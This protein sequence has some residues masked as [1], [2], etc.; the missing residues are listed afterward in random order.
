MIT[1]L[2]TWDTS[3]R[4]NIN[5]NVAA[6]H[7]AVDAILDATLNV[8]AVVVAES[9][10]MSS[11]S[12]LSLQLSTLR[13]RVASGAFRVNEADNC[14]HRLVTQVDLL[15]RGN[16]VAHGPDQEAIDRDVVIFAQ[17]A[18]LRER[19]DRWQEIKA[20]PLAGTFRKPKL[21]DANRCFLRLDQ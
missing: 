18:R 12:E 4:S 5:D 3:R 10:V 8:N 1:L 15:S 2:L 16:T 9:A 17:A 14:V 6:S 7:A 11:N 21:F 19:L 20:F 13:H